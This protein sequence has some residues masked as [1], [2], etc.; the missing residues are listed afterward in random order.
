MDVAAWLKNLGL[1]RYEAA[2]RDNAIDGDLLPSLTAEDLRD[3]GVTIVGHRRKLLDAIAALGAAI[4]PAPPAAS[5]PPDT[6]SVSAASSR[7]RV[8][9]GADAERRPITV[10]FCDLVGSTALASRLD[11][12][13]WRSLANAYLD[14]ASAAVAGLGGHVLKRLG[15]GLMALFGYPTAQEND[16]ER[17]V[18]AALAIQRALSEI[19]ARNASKARRNSPRASDSSLGRWW[20]R[21]RARCSA[22]RRISPL[23]CRRRPTLARCSSP[24]M[25]SSRSRGS[26]SSKTKARANSRV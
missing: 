11:A 1:G 25:F 18:R 8:R 5:G 9:S 23:A 24:G 20:S 10:M 6:L 14:E 22:T 13:D 17:A 19:N 26:L 21:R 4:K 3:L 15:D 7:P 16:A 2:F 12:E